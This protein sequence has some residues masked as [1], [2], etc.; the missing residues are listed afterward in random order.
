MRRSNDTHRGGPKCRSGSNAAQRLGRSALVVLEQASKP[1][2]AGH[3][4]RPGPFGVNRLFF[5]QTERP[6][7]QPLVR[8][9]LVV[10]KAVGLH[11]VVQVR[12]GEA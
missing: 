3:I 12:Q 1:L 6:V 2:A 7:A 4:L 5:A 9:E 10:V 11:D 8:P